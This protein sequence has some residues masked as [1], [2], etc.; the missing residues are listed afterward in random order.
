MIE[1]THLSKAFEAERGKVEAVKDISLE[2]P[3]GKLFTLLG[4]SGCGKSTTLR[5]VAG[6]EKPE[7]GDITVGEDTYFSSR[8]RVF[9]PPHKRGIGMVFQSYAI[10]PHMKV[11]DNV[12]YPL[13]IQRF[14][15]AEVRRK[16]EKA[17]STVGLEGLEDRLAPQ[18]SG[19]QQQ[20]V[21]LA[22]AL[23]TEP[24]ILLLDEPLSN[25]DAKLREQM[26]LEI[27]ELQQRLKVTTLYVTH[28]QTEALAISDFIAVMHEGELL[29]V[30]GP[31]EIYNQPKTKFTADFVGLI[32]IFR[33]KVVG[34][35]GALG[36]VDTSIGTFS[37]PLSQE[38]GDVKEVV[39]FIRP[40]N[41][42][43]SK[44]KPESKDNAFAGKIQ[45]LIFLG[46]MVDGRVL[47]GEEILRARLHPS[48][49]FTEN[50]RVY[51]SI[52][53]ESLIVI[54]AE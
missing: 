38:G 29:D 15:R 22:R 12:A 9:I 11:F 20:R 37:C 13:R 35:E 8:E 6:L 28:D 54:P 14:P 26:R 10:W 50:E 25:L 49:P 18:L 33:G 51:L 21:A 3:E 36:R 45:S 53:P 1:I 40:E 43:V 42:R 47:V 52:E 7:A 34:R 31:K 48:D 17:L 24:K 4:P 30:G 2:V 19:G 41:V 27:K 39:L 44:D 16:V 32:N 5:C 23:V 46:E